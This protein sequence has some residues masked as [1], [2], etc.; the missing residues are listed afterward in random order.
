MG[1]RRVAV[2]VLA[3]LT[4]FALLPNR[5]QAQSAIVGVVKDT[6]GG[7]IPGVTVEAS[8]PAL[9]E[10]VRT[11]VTDDA[12]QYL[13]VDLRPG[14][15]TVTFTLQGFNT[16]KRDGIE[17]PANFTATV[18]AE[19]RVGALE[20]TITVS[21]E[22]PVV[23]THS[24][25]RQQVMS[26]E[27][28][29]SVP[30][31]R[32]LWAYGATIPSLSLAAPD[33]GGTRGTQYV[34]MISHG[35][36]H[37]DNAHE[38]DGFNMKPLEADGAWTMYHDVGM[39]EEIAYET[40]GST[41]GISGSGV[42]MKLVPKEGGNILKGQ[43]FLSYVPGGW[44]SNNVTSELTARGLRAGARI[45]R[46]FD[47]NPNAGGPILRDRLWF[48][49]S[50]RYWGS[51]TFVNNS[52]FNLDTT[53][54]TYRPD[55]SRQVIDD[56]LLKS[57]MARLTWQIAQRHKF[58]AYFD[59]ITKFR[60]HECSS[61]YA[62]EA[63]GVR[64]PKSYYT[65]DAKYTGTLSN[66]LL[67]E[68]G[69]AINNWTWS[70]WERQRDVSQTAIPRFD[71]TLNTRWSAPTTQERLWSAPRL[72][73]AGSVSYVTGSHAFKTGLTYDWGTSENWIRLGQ[74][75]VVDLLQEYLN[76]VPASV[77]AYNTPL[78]FSNRLNYDVAAY[79]Q[80]SWK[81]RRLTFS[82]GLRV[83]WL[84]SEIRP[85]LSGAGRFVPAREFAAEKNM[86]NWGPD[87][88]PRFSGAYDLFGDGKT[89]LKASVGK[90]VRA[91]ALGFAS[92][93]NPMRVQTDRRTW[94]DL[95]GDDVAQD[96]EI[97]RVNVPFD[98][99]GVR[100]RNPDP[101]IK[102]SY[103]WEF[104]AG[105]Q[106]QLLPRVAV[107]GT[108][109]R[110]TWRRL[111]WSEN[112]LVTQADYT[113]IPI[114]NPIDPSE[115]IPVYSLDPAK[116]GRVN[117]LDRNSDK[118]E[119]WNNGFDFDVRAR[120]GGGNVFAGLSLD[121]QIRVQCETSDPNELRFCDQS[122][123]GMPYKTMFKTAGMY[124]LPYGI[125]VSGSFQSNAGGAMRVDDG[126]PWQQVSYNVTRA[127]LPGLTQ[128][129]VTVPLIQPGS[130]YLPR[131]NQADLRLAK[132]FDIGRVRLRAQFDVYNVTNSNSITDM[133]QIF[134]PALDRVNEIIP[135]RVYGFSTRIDF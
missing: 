122:A 93:Y 125:E 102:R 118:I 67:V 53:R 110:R 62:A 18:N 87:V 120:V 39:F 20:E 104:S 105:I 40:T 59:H 44:G 41:A 99:V 42:G 13:I 72:V 108:W 106:R 96:N 38:I 135:G 73:L 95:N 124:P 24:G 75:G 132:R 31:G 84:N 114:Q 127:V 111:T 26:R 94:T 70:N 63:C 6:T 126:L 22:S 16:F 15:Y 28:L 123:F 60:G 71:R 80:D 25:Q 43:V 90:Y 4:L 21:G 69:F 51:D 121:R 109:V 8:S 27:L 68:G 32:S 3:A 88:S 116:L 7:V 48:F 9:I 57:G 107:S 56:N 65:G 81:I 82:P 14:V 29:D 115:T 30:T 98:L 103:Q 86:P 113:P 66:R 2:V 10:K 117:L 79:V 112:L 74:T 64:F 36:Y 128:S 5:L 46:T 11:V 131:Y 77:V 101:D 45:H 92:L 85:Q 52:F 35:S 78:F 23:D 89:A 12:G 37:S 97:G 47:F 49:G 55:L 1:S 54:R 130:K 33:V 119:R 134:G 50:F 91:Q 19:L 100:T 58:G 83:E 76:G 17:L 34:A 129:S 133:G 61:L